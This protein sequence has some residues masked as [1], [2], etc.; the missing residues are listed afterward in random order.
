MDIDTQGCE[1]RPKSIDVVNAVGAPSRPFYPPSLLSGVAANGS[2][3]PLFLKRH[4]QL[5]ATT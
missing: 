3:L 1:Q 5:R 2:Q 4:P